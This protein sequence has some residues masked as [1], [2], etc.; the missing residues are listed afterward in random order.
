METAL[1]RF[2]GVQVSGC[3][4]NS[5]KLIQAKWVKQGEMHRDGKDM[6]LVLFSG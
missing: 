2:K 6:C 1:S 4:D 5:V 3:K